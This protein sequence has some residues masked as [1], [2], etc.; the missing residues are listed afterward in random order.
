M[1]DEKR[2]Y[3]YVHRRKTDGRIFYV[4][5]GSANRAWAMKRDYNPHW[6]RINKKHG[7]VVEICQYDMLEED[8]FL[9]EGWLIAKFRHEGLILANLTDGGEGAS[10]IKF[11]D[12]EI[13]KRRDRATGRRHSEETKEKL[14]VLML[15]NQDCGT[16]GD[17]HPC[18]DSAIRHFIHADGLEYIG[19]SFG[20]AKEMSFPNSAVRKLVRDKFR[21]Y[22][23]WMIK[24][25]EPR[26]LGRKK[27]KHHFWGRQAFENPVCKRDVMS[28]VNIDGT[29]FTGTRS[30]FYTRFNLHRSSVSGLFNGRLKSYRGWKINAHT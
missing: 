30:E 28:F 25:M 16:K 23:G 6:G 22:L 12:E 27:E 26:V 29:E 14:R 19:T 1:Q 15:G 24:G 13:Q 3:V 8:S 11:S 21:T 17:L 2:F 18:Y 20:F 5:K 9:L 4:G 7:T 10:G